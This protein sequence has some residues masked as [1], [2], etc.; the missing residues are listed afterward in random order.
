MRK[1]FFLSHFDEDEPRESS[2]VFWEVR[3]EEVSHHSDGQTDDAADDEE[4]ANLMSCGL[5]C[6]EYLKR[7]TIANRHVQDG[8]RGCH[9]P[10]LV[11]S[12]RTYVLEM[13]CSRRKME[14][15]IPFQRVTD[16]LEQKVK[17]AQRHSSLTDNI[18]SSEDIA[19]V[20]VLLIQILAEVPKTCIGKKEKVELEQ[21]LL[22]MLRRD[23]SLK[24]LRLESLYVFEWSSGNGHQSQSEQ[25]RFQGTPYSAAIAI[26]IVRKCCVERMICKLELR[27]FIPALRDGPLVPSTK[28]SASNWLLSTFSTHNL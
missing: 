28:P 17:T 13:Q 19:Q 25:A 14:H 23:P 20:Y 1:I 22:L 4:P 3:I 26:Y 12:R 6:M 2:G 7:H 15:P 21:K 10:L 9:R 8:R 24:H 11:G 27:N 5:L 16:L 18:S